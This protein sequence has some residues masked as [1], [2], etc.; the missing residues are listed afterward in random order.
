MKAPTVFSS[1]LHANMLN[2]H[3]ILYS[4]P[5]INYPCPCIVATKTTT[6]YSTE[7]FTFSFKQE[8]QTHQTKGADK[9]SYA[10][11]V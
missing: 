1:C 9:Q 5:M 8:K 10:F 7:W 2:Q 3:N 4:T 6:F 11:F